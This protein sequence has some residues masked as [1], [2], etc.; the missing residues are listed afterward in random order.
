MVDNSPQ[1]GCPIAFRQCLRQRPRDSCGAA[2][3]KKTG[4]LRYLHSWKTLGF[5]AA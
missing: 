3:S 2:L 1:G 5:K 4:V